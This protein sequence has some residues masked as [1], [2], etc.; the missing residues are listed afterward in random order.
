MP[1][2]KR[3]MEISVEEAGDYI[4]TPAGVLITYRTDQFRVFAESARHNFLRRV[5]SKYPWENLLDVVVEQGTSVRLRDVTEELN[6]KIGSDEMSTEAVLEFCYRSNP[7][8]L[9]FLRRYFDDSSP[10]Q[11]SMP[12]S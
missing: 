9:F 12:P 1:E 2:I 3:I 8:Q 10:S 7:R 6:T 5:V 4:F 11:A